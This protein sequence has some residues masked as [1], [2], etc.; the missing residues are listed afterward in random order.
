VCLSPLLHLTINLLPLMEKPCIKQP[1]EKGSTAQVTLPESNGARIDAT[2][3]G[4]RTTPGRGLRQSPGGQSS[5]SRCEGSGLMPGKSMWGSAVDKR[6]W[7]SVPLPITTRP[8]LVHS[9]TVRAQ[10]QRTQYKGT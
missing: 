3:N 1:P 10:Y 4:N 7:D 5:T 6:L 8:V 9:P 2:F